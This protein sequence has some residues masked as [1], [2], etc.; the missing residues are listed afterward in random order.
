MK[1]YFDWLYKLEL[2]LIDE[3]KLSQVYLLEKHKALFYL[4][5]YL[6]NVVIFRYNGFD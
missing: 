2:G 6:I 5:D 1:D 3:L 4:S